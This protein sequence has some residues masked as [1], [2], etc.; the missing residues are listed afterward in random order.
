M[1]LYF[2]ITT[3]DN[4]GEPTHSVAT[5]SNP[6][7]VVCSVCANRETVEAAAEAARRWRR[8]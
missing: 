1:A 6:A 2:V 7:P 8:S 5:N 4:C 3:C